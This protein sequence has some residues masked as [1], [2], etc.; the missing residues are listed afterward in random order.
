MSSG[1]FSLPCQAIPDSSGPGAPWKQETGLG[2]VGWCWG[3]H[4]SFISLIHS[5]NHCVSG[6]LLGT[7]VA[8]VNSLL[9]APIKVHSG[10][11]DKQPEVIS[12][13]C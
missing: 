12:V 13:R 11:G 9:P 10:G 6:S 5:L 1:P 4:L 3:A 8:P 7:G 2:G